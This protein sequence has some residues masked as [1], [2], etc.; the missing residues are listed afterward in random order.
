[1]WNI[2]TWD[3]GIWRHGDIEFLHGPF[4][5]FHTNLERICCVY[6]TLLFSHF[7]SCVFVFALKLL[8]L[9]PY[10]P[11]VLSEYNYERDY[12]L[13]VIMCVG[14]TM[15]KETYCLSHTL[16]GLISRHLLRILDH[17]LLASRCKAWIGKFGGK[18]ALACQLTKLREGVPSIPLDCIFVK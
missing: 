18:T 17:L 13:G 3:L 8:Y 5:R 7:K 10:Q 14:W 11:V 1:M 15:K 2:P 12:L 4:K 16:V 6:V 9:R